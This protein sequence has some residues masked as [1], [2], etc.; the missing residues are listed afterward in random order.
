[1]S[2]ANIIDLGDVPVCSEATAL[3]LTATDTGTWAFM[4]SFNG[5]YQYV[6]FPATSGQNIVVPVAL[7][8]DYR[9]T[10]KLYKP[11]NSLLNEDGYRMRT[12]P[13][14]PDVDYV[15]P[16]VSQDTAPV[17][18]GKLQLTATT[19]Q[20]EIT[21]T[22]L[23]N[24]RQVAVFVEGAMRQEGTDVDEYSFVPAEDK[25]TFNTGLIEGQ[26]ITI[27]YFK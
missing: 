20:T 12:I 23:V 1:M 27:I 8:E 5:A 21:H 19:D 3:P 6:Q 22:E 18:T 2:T 16:S 4:T 14:L 9:Y 26:K 7:N 24:A 13:L 11:D 10:F 17:T 15:C 25:I